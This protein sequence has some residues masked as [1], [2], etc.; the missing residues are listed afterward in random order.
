M[1]LSLYLDNVFPGQVLGDAED[2]SSFG[3]S[4]RFAGSAHVLNCLLSYATFVCICMNK[5]KMVTEDP[6]DDETYE[7]KTYVNYFHRDCTFDLL[8]Q[9]QSLHSKKS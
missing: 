5:H 3:L 1:P 4:H 9:C 7:T 2:L 6:C 8:V